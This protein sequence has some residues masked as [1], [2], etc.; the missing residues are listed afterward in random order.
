MYCNDPKLYDLYAKKPGNVE[1]NRDVQ[2]RE[3]IQ[4]N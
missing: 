4:A 3:H 1:Q 2:V